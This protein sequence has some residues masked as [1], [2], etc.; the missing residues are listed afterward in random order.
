MCTKAIWLV[1]LLKWVC[2]AARESTKFCRSCW[3]D[4][5]I[6]AGGGDGGGSTAVVVVVEDGDG[7]GG[8]TMAPERGMDGF[9]FSR[10]RLGIETGV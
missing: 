2:I 10:P 8:S 5:R 1:R 3:I 6:S 7:G 4:V 9:K